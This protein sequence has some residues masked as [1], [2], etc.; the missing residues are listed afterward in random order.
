MK[1]KSPQ[2]YITLWYAATGLI[3][4]MLYSV[5]VFADFLYTPLIVMFSAAFWGWVLSRVIFNNRYK[6]NNIIGFSF[7]IA[8]LSF[9]TYAI[10][11]TLF[12]PF[13]L[14]INYFVDL[15]KMFAELKLFILFGGSLVLPAIFIG[16]ALSG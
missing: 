15:D 4:A 1:I 14:P 3:I 8:L 16:G 10:V 6:R 11:F 2:T 13:V 9:T 7:L 12:S 5:I